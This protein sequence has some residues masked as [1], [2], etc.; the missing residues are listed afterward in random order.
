[1]S[2]AITCS[3]PASMISL[4]EPFDGAIG[5]GDC[6]LRTCVSQSSLEAVRCMLKSPWFWACSPLARPHGLGFLRGELSWSCRLTCVHGLTCFIFFTQPAKPAKIEFWA[7]R[8]SEPNLL[9]RKEFLRKKSVL[10]PWMQHRVHLPSPDSKTGS[11]TSLKFQKCL[12]YYKRFQKWF[13]L[14]D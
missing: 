8:A 11:T 3:R 13:C 10:P 1:M 4:P 5:V 7:V 6:G 14:F 12:H 2:V 9:W